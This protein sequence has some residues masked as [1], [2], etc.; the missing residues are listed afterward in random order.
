[1]FI[2]LLTCVSKRAYYIE[3]YVYAYVTTSNLF[4]WLHKFSISCKAGHNSKKKLVK[5]RTL[6]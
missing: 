3:L 1:M 2:G 4:R 5:D 6:W